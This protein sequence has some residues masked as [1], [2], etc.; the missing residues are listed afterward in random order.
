[1]SAFR[2]YP[3]ARWGCGPASSALIMV[4]PEPPR[5]PPSPR[6]RPRAQPGPG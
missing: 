4:P 6:R 1:V 3:P 2:R 5:R